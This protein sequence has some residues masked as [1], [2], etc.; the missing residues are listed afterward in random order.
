MLSVV[1]CIR[2]GQSTLIACRS[3]SQCG[4]A[5]PLTPLGGVR[6]TL[7]RT[8]DLTSSRIRLPTTYCAVSSVCD[9][10]ESRT[11]FAKT[12]YEHSFHLV[13]LIDG[14]RFGDEEDVGNKRMWMTT[15]PSVYRV[16]ATTSHGDV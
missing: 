12:S 5:L 11:G 2:Q 9:V 1:D 3:T 16:G 4:F 14:L 7:E 10:Q 13:Q 8:G 6:D 15:K